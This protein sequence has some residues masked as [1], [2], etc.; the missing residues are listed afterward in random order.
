M[1]FHTVRADAIRH[2][3]LST[4]YYGKSVTIAYGSGE[5]IVVAKPEKEV[6]EERPGTDNGIEFVTTRGF[7]IESIGADP[8]SVELDGIVYAVE[9]VEKAEIG[10]DVF[11]RLKT[12]R[13]GS[14]LNSRDTY[15]KRK[16]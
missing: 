15:N 3:M 1:S 13:I 9:N 16:P 5:S 7:L 12:K 8:R 11:V 14:G 4:D 2:T 10:T 6:T